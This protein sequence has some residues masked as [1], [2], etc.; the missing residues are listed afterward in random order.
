MKINLLSME[1]KQI[2]RV[3]QVICC[4]VSSIFIVAK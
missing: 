2:D 4:L 1:Y 3:Y